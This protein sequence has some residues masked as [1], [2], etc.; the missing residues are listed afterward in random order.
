MERINRQQS[1]AYVIETEA[2]SFG[3]AWASSVLPLV[4]VVAWYMVGGLSVCSAQG[5]RGGIIG[6][7]IDPTQAAV[8]KATVRAK[9]IE[10]GYVR[11]T[12]TGVDGS[13]L[14]NLL[15]AGRYRIEVTSQG[16]ATFIREPITVRATE[17]TDMQRLSL[18]IGVAAHLRVDRV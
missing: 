13:F 8:A 16:F 6:S 3:E 5:D 1:D 14:F 18:T 15:E 9:S 2:L 7:V 17:T 12:R 11:E 10:T 4:M